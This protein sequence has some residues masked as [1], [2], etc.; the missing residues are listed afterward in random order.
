MIPAISITGLTKN[1][2]KICAVSDL[3]LEVGQGDAYCLLG[4]NGAGKSTTLNLMLGLTKADAGSIQ[5]FG[6][7]P[8]SIAARNATGNVAQD[9]DFPPNLTVLEV[10]ELVRCHYPSPRPIDELIENFG[11]EQLANRLTGG[12]SGGQRRRLALALAFAGN[13]KIVFLDEPTTGLDSK[14]RKRFWEYSSQYLK[15]GGTLVVT[16]HHL[17][18]IESIASRICLIDQGKVKLE[19]SVG[20][21]QQR[22]GQK[23]IQFVCDRPP[24][25]SPVLQ[26]SF[27]DGLCKIVT[28]NGDETIRQLVH[29][30]VA[31]SNLEIRNASLEEAIEKL[32]SVKEKAG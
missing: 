26:S 27:E 5:L 8:H 4:P 32:T 16:T 15:Q 22:L 3:N 1:Y 24:E 2:G 12:F 13:G 21:I 20:E 10:L 25:L 30:G 19:G 9:N 31:F 23:Y 14:T 6:N 18:E 17:D 28:S 29:S 11:L 7:S